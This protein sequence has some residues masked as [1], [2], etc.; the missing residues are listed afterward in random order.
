VVLISF[1]KDFPISM[2]THKVGLQGRKLHVAVQ[3][4]TATVDHTGSRF[5]HILEKAI[6]ET[7]KIHSLFIISYSIQILHIF[8]QRP[9]FFWSF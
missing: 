6:I 8:V 1:P 5:C 3:K 2:S 7:S 9:I 4:C